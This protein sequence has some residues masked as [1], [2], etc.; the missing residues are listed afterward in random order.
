MRK[1]YHKKN[2][3]YSLAFILTIFLLFI[4]ISYAYLSTQ[5]NI[6]GSVKGITQNTDFIIDPDSNPNLRI[7]KPTINKWQ[8]GN[9]Y[10]YQYN[11]ILSNIGDIDYDNFTVTIWFSHNITVENCWN[12]DESLKNDVLTINNIKYDL[13]ANNSLEIGFIVSSNKSNLT[14]KKVK[15]EA[16]TTTE[17]VDPSK[18]EVVFT[19]TGGWGNYTYQYDV[20]LTNKTGQKITFWQIEITLPEGTTY[21]TGWN[22]IFEVNDTILIIKNTS[23][24]GR[25]NNNSS[26]SFG[27]QLNTNIVNY[28]PTNPKIII[29]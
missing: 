11:F 12:Y 6:S 21:V 7:N 24:N 22:G 4:S 10:K 1:H 5:L 29:R 17:Q 26:T 2:H 14:I 28:L 19:R 15:L 8:E 23:S 13:L 18:F 9:R 3:F 20:K 16:K 27:L 25:L